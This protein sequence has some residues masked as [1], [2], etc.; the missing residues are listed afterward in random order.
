MRKQDVAK[1]EGLE[2]KINV[3]K[4]YVKL[5]R[6][7]EET[8][9]TQTYHRL[10][11]EVGTQRQEVMGD[12]LNFCN[13]FGKNS[14]VDAILITFCMFLEPFERTRFLRFENRLKKIK[15]FCHPFAYKSRLKS[16]IFGINFV[17]YN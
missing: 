8:N 1:G 2:P 7:E 9:V 17:N 13:F 6:C 4:I 3:F 11:F 16:I 14:N 12:F 10:G 5:W 15:L